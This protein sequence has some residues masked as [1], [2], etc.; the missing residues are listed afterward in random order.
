MT[1]RKKTEKSEAEKDQE[2]R[3]LIQHHIKRD[4]YRRIVRAV[5]GMRVGKR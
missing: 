4:L 1:T 5:V 2:R 3:K